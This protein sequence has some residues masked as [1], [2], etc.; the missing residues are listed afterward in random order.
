MLPRYN[1]YGSWPASGEIDLSESRGNRNLTV[2]GLNVGTEL[3]AS[4]L[5]FGPYAPANR[6][7]RTHFERRSQPQEGFDRDFHRFQMEWTKGTPSGASAVL[8]LQLLASSDPR[9]DM[10]MKRL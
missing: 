9:L 5:H 3:T 8:L 7:Q 2:N 6:W 1:E 4:T 10:Y